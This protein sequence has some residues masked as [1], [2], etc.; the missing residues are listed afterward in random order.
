MF[1][2]G[3]T[4]TLAMTKFE[5]YPD[6]HS[7]NTLVTVMVVFEFYSYLHTRTD[8]DTHTDTHTD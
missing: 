6:R 8:T 7:N 4:P 2:I 5:Y 3:S 1:I